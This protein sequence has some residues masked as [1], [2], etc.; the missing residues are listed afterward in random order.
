VNFKNILYCRASE[1]MFMPWAPSRLGRFARRIAAPAIW[2]NWRALEALLTLQFGLKKHGLRPA[3]RIEDSIHCAT[4]IETP[5]FYQA[6]A[7][8]T[9]RMVRGTLAACAP[10]SV[11]T[12]TGAVLPAQLVVLA[13]GWSQDVPFLEES[14][15]RKLIEPDGLYRLYRLIANP[16]LP[17]LGFVGFN[18]SFATPLSAEL[19]A[20]WLARWFDARLVGHVSEAEMRSDIAR[21]LLWR[22][23]LRPIA[24]GFSGLCIAPY[25]FFHFDELL[26]DMGARTR[27]KNPIAAYFLPLNPA[28]YA[29]L[30]ATAPAE[31]EIVA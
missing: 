21:A 19:G 6:V 1:V 18:S 22:R 23:K 29:T 12:D 26:R 24:A 17:G 11:T 10:G 5:G 9:I 27:P 28:D 25:H 3:Q 7:R 14:A 8:G 13:I 4:S 20:H 16:D 31:K 30:L 15:R 2:A